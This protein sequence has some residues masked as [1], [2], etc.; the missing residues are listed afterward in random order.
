MK[1]NNDAAAPKSAST[2]RLEKFGE[3]I[4]SKEF[5]IAVCVVLAFGFWMTLGYV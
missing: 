1:K 5:Y 4:K 2:G 3:F